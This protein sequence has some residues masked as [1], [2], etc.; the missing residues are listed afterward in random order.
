VG[1]G[2]RFLNLNEGERVSLSC[3]DASLSQCGAEGNSGTQTRRPTAEVSVCEIRRRWRDLSAQCEASIHEVPTL[4]GG[5]H[6]RTAWCVRVADDAQ[7]DLQEYC[8][9]NAYAEKPLA[10]PN[11]REIPHRGQ[12]CEGSLQEAVHGG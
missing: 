6:C 2:A 9:H 8:R 4:N 1:P 5:G 7:S 12:H 3:S 11:P 10:E